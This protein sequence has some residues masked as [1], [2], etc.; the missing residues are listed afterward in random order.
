M[1]ITAENTAVDTA[2]R[3]FRIEVPQ[4][5]L[6]DLRARVLATR[7][8]EKETV[9]DLSQGTPLATS[10]ALARY[11]ATE[12]DWR[13]CEAR[14]N[15]HPHFLTE[16]DGLDIHFLH[17]RSKHE[18]ALPL[19]VCHGWPGSIVEQL[20]IIEPLTN[21]TAHGG[22]ASDAFHLVI[23]SMP[24]Y[25]YSGK[26]TET[27]W[28]PGR[29]ARAY[30][31]LMRRLG[32]TRF[33]AQGGDWGSVIVD[34][35]ALD[36][37]PELVGIHANMPGTVPAELDAVLAA[38]GQA[39]S[40]LS[41]DERAACD[42]L[43]FFYSHA[44]YA[45]FMGDRP[46]S[47]TGIADSPVG[48]AAFMLDHDAASLAVISRSFDG[49][50]EGL[51]PDDVLDNITH[52]WLTNSGVSAARIY[53]ENKFSFFAVKGVT[54][55]V[56]VS[57]YPDELYQAPRSWAEKAYPKLVH[58]NRLEKGGHFAAW[59]QPESFIDEVRTGLRSLR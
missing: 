4:A 52:F 5:D 49:V 7:W 14:I 16:L 35:M 46:Q 11:W 21:P 55:P 47:L 17:V 56:A 8:P 24:G 42:Q 2:V 50:P 36:A 40:G 38:G 22:Q 44:Y 18:D 57:A 15:S 41:D 34:L 54:I 37:P 25:G 20:K 39:P 26:P 51:T 32:Y 59:E 13:K 6:E 45:Y 29:I 33:A 9:D 30:V 23:P 48:L 58:Y 31:E 43:S 53:W 3:P 19:L 1:A 12:Y 27:G 28:G 10:Q